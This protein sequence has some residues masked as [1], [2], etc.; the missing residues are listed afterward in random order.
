[1]DQAKLTAARAGNARARAA[2]LRALQDGW[3]RYAVA[4]LLSVSAARDAVQEAGLRVL[5][6][7]SAYDPAEPI[8]TWSLGAV[9]QA[10]RELRQTNGAAPPLLAAAR[11]AGLRADPPRF[12]RQ[13]ADVADG[14]A[15][16]LSTMTDGQREAVVLR[17]IQRRTTAQTAR[18]L[19]VDPAT[20]RASV[21][22]GLAAVPAS[23]DRLR[24]RLEG[25]RDW[26]DLGRYPGNLQTE[27]FRAHKPGWLI[28][29]A[30]GTLAASVILVTVAGHYR[31]KAMPATQAATR[32][33]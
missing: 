33:G 8:E 14:L 25:C 13:A 3:F 11:Q 16:V 21:V 4:N 9:V 23:D 7:L 31:P 18:L 10:V 1:M 30:I 6:R 15:A 17:L 27:L 2:V 26:A 12:Q 29:A 24:A 28:P 20:V 19:G 5:G 22:A 32:R